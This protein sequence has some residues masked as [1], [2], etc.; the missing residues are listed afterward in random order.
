M[1]ATRGI[2]RRQFLCYSAG[3]ASLSFISGCSLPRAPWNRTSRMPVIGYL[4]AGTSGPYP[5][6]LE[7][8][9][10]GLRE[11]R[12]RREP[13]YRHRISVHRRRFGA[14]FGPAAELADLNV[15]IIVATG[16]EAVAAAKRVT[17][18]IPIVRTS[19]GPTQSATASLP[20][21]PVPG[22]NVTGL[23]AGSGTGLAAK[24]LQL[25]IELRPEIR[26]VG[27]LWT[28][29]NPAKQVDIRD[30]RNIA[31]SSESSLHH[32]SFEQNRT[33]KA[34]LPPSRRRH[35]RPCSTSRSS[36]GGEQYPHC[37]SHQSDA[38]SSD[39]RSA[40]LDQRRRPDALRR[41]IAWS[42]SVEPRAT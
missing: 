16:A 36:Y 17:Q 7:G 23:A 22:G 27:I 33:S 40:S 34:R 1:L 21:S 10:Q 2:P 9:R 31:P 3:L 35:Q 5:V 24:R 41:L 25:L 14:C 19:S 32:R 4:G 18:P 30:L 6:L 28:T 20:V 42:F 38:A 13:E 8:F 12:L 15:D 29:S 26:R 11:A 37:C 39:L